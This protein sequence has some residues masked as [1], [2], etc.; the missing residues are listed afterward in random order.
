MT[1]HYRT[2]PAALHSLFVDD[3]VHRAVYLSEEL[4]ELEQERLFSRT[5]LFVG[6]ASQI[7]QAGDFI[8]TSLAGRPLLMIRQNDGSVSVLSNRCAHKGALVT[9]ARRGNARQALQC[10]YHGWSYRLDGSLITMP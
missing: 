6:H 4:F 8:T 10:P 7:P 1:P 3:R 2:D 5:W 9:A